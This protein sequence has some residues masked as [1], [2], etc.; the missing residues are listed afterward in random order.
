MDFL[1]VVYYNIS[2][3]ITDA[4]G[5]IHMLH[6]IAP[7]TLDN[8]WQAKLPKKKDLT[9]Y[10]CKDG[11]SIKDGHFPVYE[12]YPEEAVLRYLFDYDGGAVFLSDVP[13]KN[14]GL[15]PLRDIRNLSQ[16]EAF[17]GGTAQHLWS[18]YEKTRFCGRCGAKMEDGKAERAMKCP[19][20]GNTVYPRISPAVIVLIHDGGDRIMLA[21][22]LNFRGGFYSC[23]AGYLEIG[24]SMEQCVAREALEEV[25]LHLKD[26][27]YFGNQPWPFTDTHMV[28]FFAQADPDEPITIQPEELADARWFHKDELPDTPQS[29][30]I[31]SAMIAKWRKDRA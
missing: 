30:A 24:E 17:M 9:L 3:K 13:A 12:D 20:C 29:I 19:A 7:H 5:N 23:I 27:T 21:R 6:D 22:G 16:P 28:G 15:L 2:R 14:G 1:R 25:G 18:W 11:V 10:F 8:G 31:A 26:I 4:G